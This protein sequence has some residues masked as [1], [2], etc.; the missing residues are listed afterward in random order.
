LRYLARV[1]SRDAARHGHTI[2]IPHRQRHRS[3]AD[4][5]RLDT[6]DRGRIRAAYDEV[7]AKVYGR[8]VPDMDIEILSWTLVVSAPARRPDG[9][10]GRADAHAPAPNG[11]RSMFDGHTGTFVEAP[12]YHR[13]AL[14]PGASFKGPCVIVEGQTTT[15]VSSRFTGQ[16][17]GHRH[18][19][20]DLIGA[21]AP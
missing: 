12:V 8:T 10:P 6:G 9:K 7:Y 20:L 11:T 14:E 1:L 2:V 13:A 4:D 5:D 16:I 3:T 19:V 18:I 15:V 17:D 21:T